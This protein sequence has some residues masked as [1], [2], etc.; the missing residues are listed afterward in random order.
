M[1]TLKEIEFGRSEKENREMLRASAVEDVKDMKNVRLHF[2]RIGIPWSKEARNA[3]V[4]YI[5]WKN[6]LMEEDLK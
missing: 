1:K 5:I 2:G 4:K 3:V 6:N